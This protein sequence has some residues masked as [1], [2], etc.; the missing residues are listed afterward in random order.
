MMVG[1]FAEASEAAVAVC[2]KGEK[3]GKGGM[4]RNEVTV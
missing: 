1:I 3:C 4:G 2:Q